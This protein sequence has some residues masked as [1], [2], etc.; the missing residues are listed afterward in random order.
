M[1]FTNWL[2]ERVPLSFQTSGSAVRPM[3]KK[4]VRPAQRRFS[5]VI[6]YLESRSMLSAIP[7][8]SAVDDVS[9]RGTLRY[10]VA[11]AQSGDTI[12][13][14]AALQSTGIT[15]TQGEL[16]L[17]QTGLTIKS[18][19]NA[20]VTISGNSISRVFEVAGGADVT[21]SNV[22]ITGGN[23][24]AGIPGRPHE[25]RGGGILVDELSTLTIKSSTVTSNSTAVLGG[26]IADYGTLSVKNSTV[27]DN[28]ALGTYGGG[29]AVFSGAPFSAPLSATLTVSDSTLSNNTAL[30]N[31]GAIGSSSSTVTVRDSMLSGNSTAV[32]DGGAIANSGSGTLTVTGCTLS[33]NVAA[34][35]G[36]GIASF[37]TAVIRDSTLSGNTAAQNGGGILIGNVG[38]ATI[39]N[40]TVSGNSAI[41]SGGGI[42]NFG[43]ST[44]SGSNLSGN[45]VSEGGAGG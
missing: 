4:R 36:G 17:S 20:S 8:T 14:A 1:S 10:A 2:S 45:E 39:N 18:A 30:Q 42:A 37:G 3:F 12:L 32:Y 7:V 35:N 38:M 6:E 24:Q 21:L 23:G 31:G 27:S 44:V 40:C 25:L 34:G 41:S 15:L 33:D 43:T 29:I 28:H 19:G 5:P 22:L 13:L 11:H 9:Q 26:G 16:L